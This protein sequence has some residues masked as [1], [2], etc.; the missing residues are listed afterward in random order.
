MKDQE[1][2]ERNVAYVKDELQKTSTLPDASAQAFAEGFV[3]ALRVNLSQRFF[4]RSDKL[5]ED[6][7]RENLRAAMEIM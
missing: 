1:A 2:Y 3:T 4:N 5:G 6:Y 7:W